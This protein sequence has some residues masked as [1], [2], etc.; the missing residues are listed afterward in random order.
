MTG[1]KTKEER[2]L[3]FTDDAW[4]MTHDPHLTPEII[5]KKMVEALAGTPASLW[6]SV[7]DHEVYHHETRVGEI[8]GEG[9]DLAE[10]PDDLR[11]VAANTRHLMETAG[12]PL[13]V[14]VNLCRRAGVEFFPR[15]RMN[16][17]YQKDPMAPD[18]GRFRNQHPEL[19]IG[20]PGEDIPRGSIEWDVRTGKD[21]GFPHDLDCPPLV[22]GQNQVEIRLISHGPRQTDPAVLIGAEV[23]ITY[24]A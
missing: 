6:W 4:I 8:V 2:P 11:K 14:L 9:Y 7:G 15:V 21:Y 24:R 16:S 17:H 20:R 10:L 12:G 13:T 19:L 23:S 1:K 18:Y 3:V 5:Q 22:Q